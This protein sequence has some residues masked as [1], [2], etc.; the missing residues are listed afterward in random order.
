MT[1]LTQSSSL[2]LIFTGF[3]TKWK[4][5]YF[6]SN[7][8]FSLNSTVPHR[9]FS[10]HIFLQTYFPLFTLKLIYIACCQRSRHLSPTWCTKR[11][12]ANSVRL[13]LFDRWRHLSTTAVSNMAVF[14]QNILNRSN[15]KRSYCNLLFHPS[16]IPKNRYSNTCFLNLNS[17]REFNF[18]ILSAFGDII[19]KNR[20]FNLKYKI[21]THQFKNECYYRE[22]I[23]CTII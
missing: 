2:L 23:N 17:H 14:I 19:I 11:P 15:T 8:T 13:Y 21:I 22:K 6:T 10:I 20:Q 16:V 7:N 1:I 4:P 5:L 12:I 3:K 18:C 9:K